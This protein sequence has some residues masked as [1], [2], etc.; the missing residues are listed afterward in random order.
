LAE[1]PVADEVLDEVLGQI[2]QALKKTDVSIKHGEKS[3]TRRSVSELREG[4]RL[5]DEMRNGRR[6][7]VVAVP[8]R[9]K[10]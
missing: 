4:A 8:R 7:P 1:G 3:V 10:L 5:A 2:G 6:S 9:P